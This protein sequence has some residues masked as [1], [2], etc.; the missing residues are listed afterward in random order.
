MNE[1]EPTTPKQLATELGVAPRTIRHWL[2]QQ[3]WQ[4]V[5]YARWELTEEQAEQVRTRFSS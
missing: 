2:R 1:H 3:G 5:P 4:T